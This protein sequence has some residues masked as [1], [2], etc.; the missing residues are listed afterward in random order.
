M[1][2]PTLLIDLF[3]N[4]DLNDPVAVTHTIKTVAFDDLEHQ[5]LALH[6]LR[7]HLGATISELA[8][9][10]SIQTRAF[11]RF[12]AGHNAMKP[13]YIKQLALLLYIKASNAHLFNHLLTTSGDMRRGR[14]LTM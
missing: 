7:E 5:S 2:N 8:A 10:M 12:I 4:I 11:E 14:V 13:V 9:L 6:A 1:T 3:F